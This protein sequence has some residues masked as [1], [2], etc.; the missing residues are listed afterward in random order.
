MVAS[1]PSVTARFGKIRVNNSEVE[2]VQPGINVW[3]T[4]GPK[5]G[6]FWSLTTHPS[7]PAIVFAASPVGVQKS[8]DGGRTWKCV[9]PPSL[10]PSIYDIRISASDPDWVWARGLDRL[11]RS[12]DAGAT[13]KVVPTGYSPPSYLAADP[14]RREV[15]YSGGTAGVSKATDG[16]TLVLLPG[17]PQQVRGLAVDPVDP[18]R[19]LVS[20][21]DG[22]FRS[23]DGGA[24]WSAAE[25]G[26]KEDKNNSTIFVFDT[27]NHEL[28]YA[29]TYFGLWRSRDGGRNW[30]LL[31]TG[32]GRGC[33]SFVASDRFNPGHVYIAGCDPVR[34]SSDAGLTWT[35]AG[36]LPP[37]FR[38]LV[39][40]GGS[41][42]IGWLAATGE[43]F[44]RSSDGVSWDSV[45]EALLPAAVSNIAVDPL[46]SR[47][48][49]NLASGI[50]ISDDKATS[51]S[52]DSSFPQTGSF[53][54]DPS[55]PGTRYLLGSSDIYKTTDGGATWVPLK[56]GLPATALEIDPA[57]PRRLYA[58][59]SGYIYTSGEGGNTWQRSLGG[60]LVYPDVNTICARANEP[61]VLYAGTRHQGV[62]RSVDLG[63]N[64]VEMSWLR[65]YP[66]RNSPVVRIEAFPSK[67]RSIFVRTEDCLYESEDDGATWEVRVGVPLTD[68]VLDA[69]DPARV[70]AIWN[71]AVSFSSNG[72][73]QW[74]KLTKGLEGVYGL[75]RC[76][77][78]PKDGTVYLA[79]DKGVYTRQTGV[80]CGSSL[81]QATT[82]LPATSGSGAVS[83]TASAGCTWLVESEDSWIKV[84]SPATGTG[85]A[86]VTFQVETNT[87]PE[88]T[89]NIRV[90]GNQFTVIQ[91]SACNFSLVSTRGQFP[92]AGGLGSVRLQCQGYSCPW[93][94]ESDQPWIYLKDHQ[95]SSCSWGA[96]FVVFSNPG[97]ARV[98]HIT[99]GGL[100]YV[101][102]QNSGMPQMTRAWG[103]WSPGE[104]WQD[105][106]T[107]DFNGDGRKD[108]IGRDS[109]TGDLWVA[110][111]TGDGFRNELWG[112]CAGERWVDVNVGDFDG[113]G[114]DDLVGRIASTG[115]WRVAV[116]SGKAFVM[117]TWGQWN[118]AIPWADVRVGHFNPDRFCDVIG[119]SPSDG[120]FSIGYS[121]GSHFVTQSCSSWLPGTGWVD[122]RVLSDPFSDVVFGRYLPTNENVYLESRNCTS[123]SNEGWPPSFTWVNVL[124]GDFN[125]DGRAYGNVISRALETGEW[126]WGDQ[127]AGQWPPEF[128]WAGVRA[129]DFN[130]D[131]KCDVVGT[132]RQTGEI[133]VALGV[134]APNGAS[135]EFRFVN[136][137]WDTWRTDVTWVDQLTGDFNGDGAA[138]L[139]ARVLETGYWYVRL[140]TPGGGALALNER[141]TSWRVTEGHT[142]R[143]VREAD[144]RAAMSGVE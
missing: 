143:R 78:D 113:D 110:V 118:S 142:Q 8:T 137:H 36:S 102:E 27:G 136:Q 11:L 89:G 46:I 26:P 13:W 69:S 84:T 77:V 45:T 127:P 9:T 83:F 43:G 98:G 17:S 37:Y 105:V 56:L 21:I 103:L 42:S 128:T 34:K 133:W 93:T 49:A 5:W 90:A 40:L 23:T 70:W 116:S 2:I 38:D 95:G 87:G 50:W 129:G 131:G 41:P 107:G 58:L 75:R 44:R 20:T 117:Q 71:Q 30:I 55:S 19:L 61:G 24:S 59:S 144:R 4:S 91:E 140:G 64:W 16:E 48:Y 120:R 88:R 104:G 51:W 108:I 138:D 18:N 79:T 82:R 57:D 114:R 122:V 139:A 94:A 35:D 126:W 97:P 28:I 125:G 3:F 123:G 99:I 81:A 92:A 73:S 62:V 63:K 22:V 124:A 101:V 68:F 25:G 31:Q 80:E 96:N 6:D 14:S 52:R 1:N 115:E 53:V 10:N 29:R 39:F 32:T 74:T 141:R 7:N 67:P 119:R 111:S 85:N 100:T 109:P 112:S 130:G 66:Y 33:I 60:G 86:E 47:A 121:D 65:G 72:G 54:F 134:T 135:S 106:Q 76:A 15:L 12:T 132:A